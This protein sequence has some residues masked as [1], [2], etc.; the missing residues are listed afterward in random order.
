MNYDTLV[1][2]RGQPPATFCTAPFE[3]KPTRFCRHP[4]SEPMCFRSTPIVRLK[5]ALR[6]S[7]EFSCKKK[8]VRLAFG[9]PP[10]KKGYPSWEI[11]RPRSQ[12]ENAFCPESSS[13]SSC[14]GRWTFLFPALQTLGGYSLG[15]F[16]P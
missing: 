10:V 4:C 8:T 6:H 7:L 15:P 13:S 1:V 11:S 12:R 14:G 2:R 5:G 9:G 3:N 16:C